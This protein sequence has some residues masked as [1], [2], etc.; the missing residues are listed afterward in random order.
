MSDAFSLCLTLALIVSLNGAVASIYYL[1][2]LLKGINNVYFN[3]PVLNAIF[4]MAPW[5]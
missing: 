4:L 2:V 1:V 5:L 3:V